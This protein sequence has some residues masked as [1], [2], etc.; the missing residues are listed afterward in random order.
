M[1]KRKKQTG[2]VLFSTDRSD[3][4]LCG[5]CNSDPCRCIS[6]AS[7]APQAQS[8]RVQRESK[9]RAGKTATV[10]YDLDLSDVDLKDLAKTLKQ[11]CGTGGTAKDGV[12]EIQGNH[13]D[14]LVAKLIELG[15]RA[16]AAG[17]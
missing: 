2:R 10:I 1:S 12:I 8:P 17:G 5:S 9:G 14:K 3:D 4:H 15:Y 11:H 7:P 6:D 13:R 16:K